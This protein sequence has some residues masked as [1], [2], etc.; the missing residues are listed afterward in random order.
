MRFDLWCA[1]ATVHA[2][3]C[4]KPRMT[5]SHPPKICTAT[6]TAF[7]FS[8]LC[9]MSL[10]IDHTRMKSDHPLLSIICTLPLPLI[11][12]VDKISVCL[13]Y[14][15]MT[16]E[17]THRASS[18]IICTLCWCGQN[19]TNVDQQFALLDL[20]GMVL[21]NCTAPCHLALIQCTYMQL[22]IIQWQL[23]V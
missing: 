22:Y 21:Y 12:G 19:W 2:L 17:I 18:I 20:R 7:V 10:H 1:L 8:P 9:P 4:G 13:H 5:S 6:L 11:A 3:M 16:S 15:R 23:N 14:M